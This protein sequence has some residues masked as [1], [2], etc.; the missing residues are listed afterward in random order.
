MFFNCVGSCWGFK[1]INT[2]LKLYCWWRHGRLSDFADLTMKLK[3]RTTDIGV[4]VRSNNSVLALW[5]GVDASFNFNALFTAVLTRWAIYPFSPSNFVFKRSPELSIVKDIV[6]IVEFSETRI[7]NMG[8]FKCPFR[9]EQ[10]NSYP[11]AILKARSAKTTAVRLFVAGTA[12]TG[13]PCLLRH[14]AVLWMD[15]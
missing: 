13:T 7:Q 8:I 10:M 9:D 5:A 3:Q 11:F 2:F 15:A 6:W 12:N 1:G 4:V 14:F